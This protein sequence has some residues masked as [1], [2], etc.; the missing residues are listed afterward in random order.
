[1]FEQGLTGILAEFRSWPHVLGRLARRAW[2]AL[3]DA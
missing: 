2:G 1:M 3:R